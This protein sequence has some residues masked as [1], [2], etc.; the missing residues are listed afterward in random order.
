VLG[1]FLPFANRERL[2][3]VQGAAMSPLVVGT[4]ADEILT[5]GADGLL[6]RGL[7]HHLVIELTHPAVGH[8]GHRYAL[9]LAPRPQ[10]CR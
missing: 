10:T 1:C 5:G 3:G 6:S 2:A 9:R 4:E 8:G 7:V